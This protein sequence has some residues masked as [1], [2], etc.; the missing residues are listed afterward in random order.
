M[1]TQKNVIRLNSE[2]LYF[3]NLDK[4]HLS[5]SELFEANLANFFDKFIVTSRDFQKLHGTLRAHM[6]SYLVKYEIKENLRDL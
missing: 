1:V 4:R 6:T 3:S 2:S 5:K